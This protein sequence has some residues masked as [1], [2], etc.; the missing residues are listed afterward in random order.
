[1]FDHL[2]A[3]HWVRNLLM[4]VQNSTATFARK[5][6]PALAWSTGPAVLASPCNS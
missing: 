4:E 5:S 1:M 6:G 2:M 3:P